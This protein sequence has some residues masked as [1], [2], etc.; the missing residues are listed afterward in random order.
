MRIATKLVLLLL[1]ASLLPLLLFGLLSV[2]QARRGTVTTVREGNVNVSRRAAAEIEQYV[3]NGL[4]ILE[5]TAENI[6]H[7]DLQ[8]WQKERILKN[9]INRFDEFNEMTVRNPD[10]KVVATS[11]LE[12]GEM[13]PFER[14]AFQAAL[15][16]K[17]HLSPVFIRNDLSPA[18]TAGFPIK[19]LA[20]VSGVLTAEINLLHM[21]YLVDGIRI[22]QKGILHIID[23]D[24]RLVA[25]GDGE[26]KPE[27]F[28]QK[29]FRPADRLEEILRPEGAVFRNPVGT[30]VLAVGT[31][32]K[33][34]L[35]WSVIVE[36]PT[37][38]AYALGTRISYLLAAVMVSFLLAALALGYS[39]GRRDVVRPIRELSRATDELARN[40]DYRVRIGTGDEFEQL[41][42]A[43]NQMAARLKELQEKLIREERHAMFGRIASGLAHDL[44]HPIQAIE[45]VSRLIDTMHEDPEFRQTFRKTVEREFS[46]INLFLTNLHNLT[47]EIPHHPVPLKVA[48][49]VK[50]A[51]ATFEAEAKKQGIA[52]ELRL[53][54][55]DFQIEGDP[56]SLNRVLSNLISNA[57][58]AMTAGGRL[59]V[60]VEPED[61][62]IRISVRDTGMGIPSE[63]LPTLFDD[64]VTTKRRGLG[65]GLAIVKKIVSQHGGDVQVES[66]VGQG[67]SFILNL[68]RTKNG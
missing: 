48:A 4:A 1:I 49:V 39:R 34:P 35:G 45:N 37:S 68:P 9:Y 62:R 50:D 24:G 29:P 38:E 3:K 65:L 41:G 56:N 11:R 18:M 33:E 46:K 47:H 57:L 42:Q 64:F 31:R 17:T 12:A 60:A 2:W 53:P 52:A 22:G 66:R 25:T 44:K 58:Q 26:R 59:T 40:L 19:R 61:H 5:S 36:Q 10:G 27:V 30:K 43:F 13:S 55:E 7:A 6:N 15:A 21:W 8:D 32:L 54:A 67:T 63:R 23:P 14:E 28:Q 20:Q 51:M 16:G